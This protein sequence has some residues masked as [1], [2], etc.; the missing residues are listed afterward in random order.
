MKKVTKFK[1][2]RI[3]ANNEL[4][5]LWKEKLYQIINQN[6]HATQKH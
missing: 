4:A 1:I 2:V 5:K 3:F 6:W